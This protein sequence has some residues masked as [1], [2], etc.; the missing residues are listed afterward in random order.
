MRIIAISN[1]KGGVGK[2]TTSVNMGAYLSLLGNKVVVLDLDPQANATANFG[3]DPGTEPSIYS[4]LLT[5]ESIA[6]LPIQTNL[7]NLCIIPSQRELA[8]VEVQLA[9]ADDHL[10]RLRNVLHAYRA[11]SP[12]D[13]MLI[14]CPP[15]LGVLMTNALAAADEILVPVQ[16]E[17]FG[18]E[19]IAKMLKIIDEI[20]ASGA[21]PELFIEGMVLTMADTRTN[22]TNSVIND[23]RSNVGDQAYQTLIPRSVRLAEAPSHCQAICEYAPDSPGAKAYKALAEEFMM[24]HSLVG[25]R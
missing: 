12:F 11:I 15:S 25:A 17:Y 9:R 13:Y 6:D 10:I 7:E 1:Q 21:N 19:G 16:C 18:I 20:I 14:D 22:L 3:V 23:V 8:N 4:A 5:R 24:R 2:T